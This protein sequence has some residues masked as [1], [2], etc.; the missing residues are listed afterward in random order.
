[1]ALNLCFENKLRSYLAKKIFIN[2][3]NHAEEVTRRQ[4][5]KVFK[6]IRR[7]DFD[8]IIE[9]YNKEKRLKPL[10]TNEKYKED[11]KDIIAEENAKVYDYFGNIKEDFYTE[12]EFTKC[13]D[14]KSADY[15]LMFNQLYLYTIEEIEEHLEKVKKE[16]SQGCKLIIRENYT[17][18]KFMEYVHFFES[19][20]L[21][22]NLT[23]DEFKKTVFTF[24]E[25]AQWEQ[26]IKNNG[27]V[28]IGY[29]TKIKDRYNTF[30][31][32]SSPA[33]PAEKA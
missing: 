18:L 3:C 7:R 26:I 16:M 12:F 5:D 6:L 29:K 31:I 25:K 8:A 30:Y 9:Y 21:Y 23:Y 27:L 33:S 32:I 10:E 17:F 14:I 2:N 24:L 13:R 22:N 11:I 28:P 15:V 19:V 20:I 4:I 1:M